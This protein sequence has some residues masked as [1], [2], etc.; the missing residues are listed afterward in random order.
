MLASLRDGT[1]KGEYEMRTTHTSNVTEQPKQSKL[2]ELMARWKVR[3]SELA[4]EE[5]NQKTFEI[6]ELDED[7]YIA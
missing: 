6:E 7:E 1:L 4:E 3:K 2:R 5:L